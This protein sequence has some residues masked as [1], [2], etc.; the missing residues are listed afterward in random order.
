[1]TQSTGQE[2]SSRNVDDKHVEDSREGESNTLMK[3]CALLNCDN[4]CRDESFPDR[5]LCIVHEAEFQ[6][7]EYRGCRDFFPRDSKERRKYCDLHD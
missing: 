4:L 6:I 1:M 5:R 3:K 7:C 2:N